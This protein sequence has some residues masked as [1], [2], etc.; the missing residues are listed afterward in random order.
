MLEFCSVVLFTNIV[1]R[2]RIPNRRFFLQSRQ[3]D[4]AIVPILFQKIHA[5]SAFFC[6]KCAISW[7]AGLIYLLD[8]LKL[9]QTH[10]NFQLWLIRLSLKKWNLLETFRFT[11]I[12]LN[13]ALDP[14]WNI[15]NLKVLFLFFIV[16][17]LWLKQISF[18]IIKIILGCLN[19]FLD[20]FEAYQFFQRFHFFIHIVSRWLFFALLWT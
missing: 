11:R 7:I 4:P 6:D 20:F 1:F 17:L 2:G 9:R 13:L 8:L 16:S 5:T 18:L 14:H 15:H 3:T 12:F 10:L 19:L